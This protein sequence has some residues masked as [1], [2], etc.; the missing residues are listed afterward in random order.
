MAALDEKPEKAGAGRENAAVPEAAETVAAESTNVWPDE[1]AEAAFL[2]DAREK[3]E[4]PGV[5]AAE[6]APSEAAEEGD[7]RNLPAL[8]DLVKRIPAE[9]RNA[10]DDLFRAKFTTVKRMPRK[11]LKAPERPVK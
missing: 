10:L 4:P 6:T 8:D 11:V 7:S 3:G 9:V 5:V 1:A 2:S